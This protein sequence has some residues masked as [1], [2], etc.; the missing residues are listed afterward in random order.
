MWEWYGSL[1][2]A[3]DG[4][5]SASIPV[6]PCMSPRS[7]LLPLLLFW[8]ISCCTGGESV[9]IERI[10]PLLPPSEVGPFAT[11]PDAAQSCAA[12]SS[13]SVSLHSLPH[14]TTNCSG[15][16]LKAPSLDR[17][18]PSSTTHPFSVPT[19]RQDNPCVTNTFLVAT[20]KQQH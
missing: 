4:F 20:L 11:V 17:Q 2:V 14:T 1:T 18:S 9:I 5:R 13:C 8:L 6:A 19:D 16:G 3:Y 7:T 10:S 12:A 15:L